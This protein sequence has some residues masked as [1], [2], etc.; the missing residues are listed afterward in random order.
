MTDRNSTS[1]PG[2]AADLAFSIGTYLVLST[3]LGMV[4]LLLRW[5][6]EPHVGRFIAGTWGPL[7]A[8]VYCIWQ[9]CTFRRLR[10]ME[11]NSESNNLIEEKQ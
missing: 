10:R 8:L 1:L 3:I 11:N 5:E 9:F 2:I 4:T 6:L 7:L